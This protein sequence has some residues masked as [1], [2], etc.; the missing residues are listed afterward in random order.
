[1]IRPCSNEGYGD[2]ARSTTPLKL[3]YGRNEMSKIT[4][5][6]KGVTGRR[7]GG[8]PEN[9]MDNFYVCKSCDQSVD[10]RDL[11]QVFHHEEAGH[12]PIDMD[13]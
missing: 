5:G 2:G 13:G 11:G 12:E 4:N 8:D 1:M 7:E 6:A 3:K 9:E 10:M